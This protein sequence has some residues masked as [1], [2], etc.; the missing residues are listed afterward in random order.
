MPESEKKRGPLQKRWL[1]LGGVIVLALIF[2][3]PFIRE[4]GARVDT[5]VEVETERAFTG[6]IRETAEGR[7]EIVNADSETV[8]A[9][10]AGRFAMI[11]VQ[12]GDLVEEGDLIA[13][14]DT[15]EL[16]VQIDGIMNEIDDLDTQIA[17]S[18]QGSTYEIRAESAGLVKSVS[19]HRGGMTGEDAL[20]VLSADGL[21][22][23]E[24]APKPGTEL[25]EDG[26]VTVR[27][28]EAE[29]PGTVLPQDDGE[30]G[31]VIVTFDDGPDYL[32]GTS[33]A[34]ID[35]DGNELGGG[36]VEINAPYEVKTEESS[37][38]SQVS[39]QP[40]D[41]VEEGDLLLTCIDADL[42]EA[43]L[44][45][46]DR[47]VERIDALFDL[48]AYKEEPQLV[49]QARGV[50]TGLEFQPGDPIEVGQK[51]CRLVATDTF[52]VRAD[53]PESQIDRVKEGQTVELVFDDAPET[54]YKGQVALIF[55]RRQFKYGQTVHGITIHLENA[56]GLQIGMEAGATVILDSA[57]D[58]VLV[59]LQ[60]V[61][62][63][64]DGSETVD[65]YYGDGLTR[66][67]T[68]ETGLRDEKNVQILRGV[69]PGED[70]VV[71]SHV[72]ETKVYSFFSLEWVVEQ[73][74]GPSE[75][76][77]VSEMET[78]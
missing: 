5:S 48:Q 30:T 28:G 40:G 53:I 13:L 36:A 75:N 2:L 39:V 33:A 26:A 6:S 20:M 61:Q 29:E 34:V 42:N 22:R 66:T 72:V 17:Q 55:P 9:E 70:V 18:D 49:A 76:G 35:A 11:A 56:E 3:I 46:L 27:L 44:A 10:Y 74:E 41:R 47:R 45:L 63:K 12:N 50:V 24:F 14:Y 62:V 69:E 15:D 1:I 7:G 68:V 32:P 21:L 64:E 78:E 16:D 25:P 65:L 58:A 67:H 31:K 57:E 8:T 4:G 23:V 71:A 77:L 19:A 52:T 54:V 59:P 73:E 38:V 43:Y 51:V 37:I 60:A